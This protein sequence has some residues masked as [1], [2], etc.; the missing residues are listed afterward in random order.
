MF[1]T[2]MERLPEY[3]S[4]RQ[5]KIEIKGDILK[6]Y[7]SRNSKSDNTSMIELDIRN[8]KIFDE[9]DKK[10][11]VF[12]MQSKPS[13]IAT[14]GNELNLDDTNDKLTSSSSS[15]TNVP[16]Q[17]SMQSDAPQYQPHTEIFFKTKSS[18]EM[19]RIVGLVQW[20]NSLIYDDNDLQG[21][22]LAEP[23]KTAATAS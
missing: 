17:Q 9:S 1:A 19:R 4:W 15:S 8:Y 2:E 20:K 12:R 7:P 14:L 3:R 13:P 16:Q 5:M 23:Q 21:K 11:Y 22:Q 6:I 10:K 18:T